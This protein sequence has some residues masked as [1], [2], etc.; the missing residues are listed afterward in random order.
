MNGPCSGRCR[1]TNDVCYSDDVDLAWCAAWAGIGFVW[2]EALALMEA[3]LGTALLQAASP[4][5]RLLP[6][7]E[8]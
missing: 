4:R 8:L 3:F 2:C 6:S 1:A 5:S 7:A